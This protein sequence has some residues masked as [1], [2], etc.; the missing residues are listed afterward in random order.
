MIE[1]YKSQLS[2]IRETN[3]FD[4]DEL[5][6]SILHT[7]EDTSQFK[8]AVLFMKRKLDTILENLL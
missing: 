4:V 6:D 5:V 7:N 1:S 2:M 3:N 8:N